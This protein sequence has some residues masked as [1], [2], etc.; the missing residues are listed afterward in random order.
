MYLELIPNIAMC[1]ITALAGVLV[2]IRKESMLGEVISHTSYP[3]I[4][5]GVLLASFSLPYWENFIVQGTAFFFGVISVLLINKLKKSLKLKSDSAL[6]FTLTFFF[7]LGVLI[8]S[9]L[10]DINPECYKRSQVFL[11]G[12]YETNLDSGLCFYLS[13]LLIF[14]LVIWILYRRI[15]LITFDRVFSKI[16][17][18]CSWNIEN[19]LVIAAIILGIKSIGLLLMSGM[20]VL[21]ALSARKWVGSLASFF[22][23]SAVFGIFSALLGTYLSKKILLPTGPTILLSSILLCGISLTAR[24]AFGS[25]FVF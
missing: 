2:M 19:I 22:I 23:I 9:I 17:K 25:K 5:L 15:E 24:R 3:G 14:V 21:P 20:L 1:I 11:Y 7:G 10:Q 6:C 13:A 12:D 4:A 8:V 16:S 18:V